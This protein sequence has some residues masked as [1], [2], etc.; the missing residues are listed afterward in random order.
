MGT[1]WDNIEKLSAVCGAVGARLPDKELKAL[2][3]GK[4]AEEAGEAMHALH[5][6]KG[7]TTCGDD[8]TWSEV[9]ND[10]VGA[11]IAALLAMHYID[12]T[13]AHATFDEIL[14]RRTIRGR[15][16]AAAA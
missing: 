16:A 2:Q 9:Q 8:H 14:H 1:L 11:V 12:R 5:G 4:V 15:E 10:L 6:L 13:G 3:V 7:L